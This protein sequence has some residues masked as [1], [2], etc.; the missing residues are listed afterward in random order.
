MD[1]T[2]N[3]LQMNPTD[4]YLEAHYDNIVKK[5]RDLMSS[6]YFSYHEYL[7]QPDTIITKY[8]DDLEKGSL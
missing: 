1:D 4:S 6:A 3:K 8:D 7:L 2:Y 5:H